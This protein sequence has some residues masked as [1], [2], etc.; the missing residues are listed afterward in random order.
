[1]P[2]RFS[3]L[4]GLRLTNQW[5]S[6][7]LSL[8]T[9][10]ARFPFL[11]QCNRVSHAAFGGSVSDHGQKESMPS[12]HDR[13]GLPTREPIDSDGIHGDSGALR[14]RA[15]PHSNGGRVA[16][17]PFAHHAFGCL[18]DRGRGRSV[19][20]FAT[21]V[22][23]VED[24]SA[25]GPRAGRHHQK[26]GRHENRPQL[27]CSVRG[28]HADGGGNRRI[29]HR[30]IRFGPS[31]ADVRKP[32]ASGRNIAPFKPTGAELRFPPFAYR[33][34]W[35]FGGPPPWTKRGKR[36]AAVAWFW[37]G[38]HPDCGGNRRIE[39]RPIQ[40]RAKRHHQTLS[41]TKTDPPPLD[42]WHSVD[43]VIH[44][45]S[46][47][48]IPSQSSRV[49]QRVDNPHDDLGR[50][51]F[52]GLR[53]AARTETSPHSVAWAVRRKPQNTVDIYSI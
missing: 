41:D 4:V 31:V 10:G 25:A 12:A 3:R 9:L 53:D 38:R 11:E 51:L 17:P 22:A 6:S 33:T 18:G 39:H 13:G 34:F 15:S 27:E 29:E 23:L 47:A 7:L 50:W 2:A 16:F 37:W 30:P 42:Q 26:P 1:M 40:F 49:G 5:L 28:G 24:G 43:G 52:F 8:V 36:T 35:L 19:E 20:K 44:A 46:T 48:T 45:L 32:G 21:A 14:D